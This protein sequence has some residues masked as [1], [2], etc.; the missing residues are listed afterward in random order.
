M[1][2]EKRAARCYVYSTERYEELKSIKDVQQIFVQTMFVLDLV[3]KASSDR[4]EL[5][6]TVHG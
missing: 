5:K 3:S 6:E 4:K 1:C 2:T